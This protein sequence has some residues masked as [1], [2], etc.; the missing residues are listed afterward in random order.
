MTQPDLTAGSSDPEIT[1]SHGDLRLVASPYGAALRGLYRQLPDGGREVI[2][3]CYSGKDN[4]VGGEGDVL[5]P[6]PG[7]VAGG[8]YSFEGREYQMECKDKDGPNAIHGFLRS[9]IWTVKAAA[10]SEVTFT[11]DFPGAA[12]APDGYPF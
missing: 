10:D 2:A 4:K 5:I 3:T 9:M 6:F 8:R 7:R 1:L 11:A 12:S